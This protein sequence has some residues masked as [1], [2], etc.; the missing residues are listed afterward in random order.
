MLTVFVSVF[1]H[2][3]FIQQR[4]SNTFRGS[5]IASSIKGPSSPITSEQLDLARQQ[6]DTTLYFPRE[7]QPLNF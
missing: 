7:P 1:F 4:Y 5:H 3:I 6:K 2:K